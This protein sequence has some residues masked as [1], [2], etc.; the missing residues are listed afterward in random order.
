MTDITWR[1][2]LVSPE[3]KKKFRWEAPLLLEIPEFLYGTVYD[4][5]KEASM[6]KIC[7]I[8]LFR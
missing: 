5:S 1:N 2:F 3:I 6:P 4:W 8:C 7:F